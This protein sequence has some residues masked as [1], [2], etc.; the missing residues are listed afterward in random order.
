VSFLTQHQLLTNCKRPFDPKNK[1]DINLLKRFMQEDKWGESPQFLPCP[2]LLED[3]YLT[4]PDMIKDK[5]IKF[6]L[7]IK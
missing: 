6:Q 7:G 4:I 2:F 1:S 5:Y 3:P